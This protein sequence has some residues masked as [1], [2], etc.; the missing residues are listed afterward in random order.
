MAW[1]GPVGNFHCYSITRLIPFSCLQTGGPGAGLLHSRLRI[2]CAG[3]R[4]I[5]CVRVARTVGSMRFDH[6]QWPK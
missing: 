2:F 4:H 6:L 1:N 5:G 3:D